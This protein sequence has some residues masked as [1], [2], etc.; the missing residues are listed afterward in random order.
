MHSMIGSISLSEVPPPDLSFANPSALLNAPTPTETSQ[1][2]Q[3]PPLI[4][5]EIFLIERMQ[6]W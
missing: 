6:F 4:F 3:Q 1:M 2:L 5:A